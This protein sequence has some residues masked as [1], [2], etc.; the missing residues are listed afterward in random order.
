MKLDF[1]T[2]E[3][4]EEQKKVKISNDFFI[5]QFGSQNEEWGL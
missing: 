1:V 2:G 3:V 5:G 4:D